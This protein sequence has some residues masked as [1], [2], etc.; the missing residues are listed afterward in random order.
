MRKRSAEDNGVQLCLVL[1]IRPKKGYFTGSDKRRSAS[2]IGKR[3]ENTNPMTDNP[4]VFISYSHDSAVHQRRVLDLANR[5]RREGVDAI[6][7]QYE[8]S[9]PG[10]W[11]LWCEAEIRKA[12]FVLMVC[13][14]T[15]FRRVN[16]EEEP[17]RGHG[18]LWEALL[19]R[20]HLYDA[21]SISRKFFPV[22][23]GDASP[24]HVPIAVKGN[25]IF[26]LETADG[27]EDLYRLLTDQPRVQK[28]DLGKLRPMPP[29]EPQWVSTPSEPELLYP[30]LPPRVDSERWKNC[31]LWVDNNHLNRIFERRDF[32]ALGVTFSL[33]QSTT[34]ALDL[35]S[36]KRFSAIISN[37]NRP[38]EPRAGYALLNTLRN[39][40]DHT[41]FF[42]YAG[43][44]DRLEYRQEALDNHAQGSTGDYRRLFRM[45]M[46]V[47]SA[48]R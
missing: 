11:T 27:Y 16:N 23:F 21:G 48:I 3:T 7:D 33:A 36:N 17:G 29:I 14:E 1:E 2:P 39:R 34:E 10:G 47:L 28:P 13:T 26:K 43:R 9:P 31:I 22:L 35:L 5:L 20:Q 24:D 12:D 25:T 37:V 45:V 30:L 19:I 40:G 8:Q 4:R 41:P 18:V 6:I 38:G 15:Y 42:F 44:G 46:P 32:E